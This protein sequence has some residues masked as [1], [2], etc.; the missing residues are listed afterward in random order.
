[1]PL[2]NKMCDNFFDGIYFRLG[3]FSNELS[4]MNTTSG[5]GLTSYV[6]SLF[7]D[8]LVWDDVKW[9]KRL[10]LNIHRLFKNMCVCL[11]LYE[12]LYCSI[13]DLPIIIKGIL[14]PAD[15]KI[16]A[17]LGCDGVFVSNHG[18]R[19]LDTSPATVCDTCLKIFLTH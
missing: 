8:R 2:C 6:M 10:L 13:T 5:S 4:E 16:A 17:D 18:G 19:Q 9:L 12:I 11:Y 14:N 7:D 15:A 1:M 3:N